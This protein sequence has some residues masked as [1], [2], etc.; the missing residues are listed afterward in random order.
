MLQS[1]LLVLLAACSLGF[2]TIG[3]AQEWGDLEISF[4]YGGDDIPPQNPAD[5]DGVGTAQ[6]KPFVVNPANMAIRNV[7][8]WLDADKSDWEA[9]E[10]HPSLAELPDT[11]TLTVVKSR[12]E[13]HFAIIRAGQGIKIA[14]KDPIEYNINFNFFRNPARN[15]VVHS[16]TEQR[17]VPTV[18]EPAPTTIQGNINASV[19]ALLLVTGNPYAGVSDTNG[20][21]MLEKLPAN[22]ELVFRLHHDRF[23]GAIKE[24]EV[25]GETRELTKNRLRLELDPGANKLEIR[26]PALDLGE[27]KG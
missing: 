21:L 17:F 2:A 10:I 26:I 16:L 24:L 14:N 20:V 23:T 1:P 27:E 5:P 9:T 12:I 19:Y 25:D 11:K 3:H 7:A 8:L 6:G 18:A 22:R 13:P 4:I 15:V